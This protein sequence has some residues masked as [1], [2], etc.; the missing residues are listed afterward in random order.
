M[1]LLLDTNIVNRMADDAEEVS[2]ALR[3]AQDAGRCQVLITHVQTDEISETKDE[4]RRAL[5]VAVLAFVNARL[6]P[7]AG[8]VLDV[9][10][11]GMARLDFA[12][13]IETVR[14]VNFKHSRDALLASTAVEEGAVLVTAD[15]PLG[16]QLVKRL[17]GRWWDYPELV[18]WLREGS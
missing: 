2:L 16:R 1:R 13:P 15:V 12:E 4:Q 7:T 5:L 10:R 6:E 3:V 14:G 11:L 8:F 18:G 9:S 17:G